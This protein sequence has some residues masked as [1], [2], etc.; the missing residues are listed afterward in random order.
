[1]RSSSSHVRKEQKLAL[2]FRQ[3]STFIQMISQDEPMVLKTYVTRVDLSADGGICYVY[4]ATYGKKEDFD[5]VL[6]VLKLYKPS[7]R[8]NLALAIRG[9]YTPDLIFLYD[10]VKE[11][12]RRINDLL[13]AVMREQKESDP[14]K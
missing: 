2:Y 10:E 14:E 9:R 6:K 13:D 7:I 1:M 3:I 12:E 4:F 8:K 5:E 11:K